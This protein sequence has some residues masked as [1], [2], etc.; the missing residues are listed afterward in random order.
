VGL[1]KKEA[2]NLAKKIIDNGKKYNLPIQKRKKK[3]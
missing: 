2:E 3:K 1:S